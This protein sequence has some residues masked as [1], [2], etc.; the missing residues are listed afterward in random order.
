MTP[1]RDIAIRYL[2]KQLRKYREEL[3]VWSGAGAFLK[4]GMLPLQIVG[5]LRGLIEDSRQL[6]CRL[7]GRP[8]AGAADDRAKAVKQSAS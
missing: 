5:T 6:Y 8:A 7:K 1:E 2:A 3:K 4:V